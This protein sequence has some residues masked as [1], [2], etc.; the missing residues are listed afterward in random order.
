M[1]E[2]IIDTNIIGGNKDFHEVQVMDKRYHVA[3]CTRSIN[4]KDFAAWCKK[5]KGGK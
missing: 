4:K 2:R 3:I 5:K 1:E